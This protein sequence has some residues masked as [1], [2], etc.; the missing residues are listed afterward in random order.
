[1]SQKPSLFRRILKT[2][3]TI[4]LVDRCLILIMAILIGQSAY[5]LFNI[6]SIT[7][8][9][10]SID[11]VVRT[12]AAAIFGYFVSGNFIRSRSLSVPP[13]QT[14]SPIPVL[15][16][17]KTPPAAAQSRI[18]FYMTENPKSAAMETGSADVQ[19][20]ADAPSNSRLQ[21]IVVS[22]VG[23]ISLCVLLLYRNVA[24]ASAATAGTLTQLRD[25]VSGCVGFLIGCETSN[26]SS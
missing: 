23:I 4:H 5:S 8:E 9:N 12:S 19:H 22:S 20:N 15:P 26:S 24:Q 21:I 10:N 2:F 17:V 3:R 16:E 11:V 6:E 13:E 18:G 25:F 14:P 1:M 7:P